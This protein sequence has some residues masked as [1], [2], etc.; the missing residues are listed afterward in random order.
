M[1]AFST[2]VCRF[3]IWVMPRGSPVGHIS[4]AVQDV[5]WGRQTR[6]LLHPRHQTRADRQP[7]EAWDETADRGKVEGADSDLSE[8]RWS[9]FAEATA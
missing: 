2:N 5:S 8:P 4:P 1:S 9:G 7:K 3:E 6:A